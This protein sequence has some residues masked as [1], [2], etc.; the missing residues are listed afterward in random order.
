MVMAG[1]EFM[2]H[3]PMDQR[4]PFEVCYIN[5]TVLDAKGR[6]MSKSAGNGIDPIEMI[7]KYGADAV[8]YSLVL[9][10]KEGQDVKLSPDRFEQ[11]YRFSNKVWNAARFV[12]MNMDGPR[13]DGTSETAAKLED[14]WILSRLAEVREE[15]SAKFD[16]YHFNDAATALYRF[17]WNDFCDWY[18]EIVKPRL[19]AK[20]DPSAPAARGTLAR[21]LADMLALLHPFTPYM[22]EA[23]WKALHETLGTKGRVPM[24]MSSPWP[25]GTGLARDEKAESEMQILQDLVG[26]I[27]QVRNLTMIGERQPLVALVSAQRANERSV[28]KSHADTVRGLAYLESFEVHDKIARPKGSAVAV[29]G[30]LEAVVPLTDDVDLVKLTDVLKKRAEKVRTGIGGIDAK[31]ANK[32]FLERADPDVVEDERARKLELTHELELLERNIAGF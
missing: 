18:L 27:R 14:R 3:L 22:T 15:V 13:T 24:L 26:A 10:T 6:R 7:D 30:G 32:N 20:S 9:L 17:V 28:L 4:C 19:L 5:A 23:L 31:L 8:R 29:S 21:V 1:Y 2:D 11:G 16:A 25:D 12:L